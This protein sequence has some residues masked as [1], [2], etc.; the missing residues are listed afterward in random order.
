MTMQFTIRALILLTLLVALAA[1]ALL[2]SKRIA[3]VKAVIQEIQLES[4]SLNF[5]GE[6]VK[7][8][9]QV[10]EL[11]IENNP[12]P[13]PYYLAAKQRYEELSAAKQETNGL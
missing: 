8:H 10:C 9:T 1:D 11:A 7:S 5:D 2:Q 12:L 13:S 6:Y 3:R 4:K